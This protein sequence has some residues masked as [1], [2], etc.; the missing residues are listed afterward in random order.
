MKEIK[1]RLKATGGLMQ[2]VGVVYPV[3]VD[4]GRIDADALVEMMVRNCNVP[5]SQVMAVLSGLAEVLTEML[6]LG[7]SVEVPWLGFF[8]PKVK[9][10]V[11]TDCK[12]AMVVGNARGDVAFKPKEKLTE[13]FSDVTYKVVSQKVRE[14]VSLTPDEAVKVVDGLMEK[15]PVFSVNDFADEAGCSPNYARRVL[16]GLVAQC[17][18]LVERFG[19]ISVYCQ[20]RE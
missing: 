9:G 15:R 20:Y 19:R 3:V 11:V 4:A 17:R 13:S 6:T 10:K 5:K 16:D 2:N 8:M 7:H 18:L 14:N 1:C 12:G